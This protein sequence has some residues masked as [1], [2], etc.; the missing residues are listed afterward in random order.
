MG[1]AVIRRAIGPLTAMVGLLAASCAATIPGT[2]EPARTPTAT[3]TL[4]AP[5]TTNALA[6]GAN[7]DVCID[8]DAR[9]GQLYTEFVVPMMTGAT[10]QKSVDVDI[11]IISRAIAQVEQ[12]G[13]DGSLDHASGKI[14]DEAERMVAAAEAFQAVD[15]F[16]GT[17]LLTSFVG[18]AVACQEAGHKP[19]WFDA[20]SLMSS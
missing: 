1:R 14:A 13:A 4:S 9:G 16:E 8:L 12:V 3:T 18:L 7:R 20:A 19:S 5:T 2:A 10:G 6:A 17:A 15:H 11:A